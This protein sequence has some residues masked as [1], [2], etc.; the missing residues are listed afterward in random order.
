MTEKA[1]HSCP[2]CQG[3]LVQPWAPDRNRTGDPSDFVAARCVNC[4]NF[5]APGFAAEQ[6]PLSKISSDLTES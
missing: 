6:E 5:L 1:V 3:L 4:G 2:R